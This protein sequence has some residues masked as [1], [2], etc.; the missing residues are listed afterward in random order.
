MGEQQRHKERQPESVAPH[1]ESRKLWVIAVLAFW[2][3]AGIT[4]VA[5]LITGELNLILAI[6][7]LGMMVLGV[8]LKARYQLQNRKARSRTFDGGTE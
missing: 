5:L 1:D 4:L 3:S 2:V 7:T 6:V 8:W